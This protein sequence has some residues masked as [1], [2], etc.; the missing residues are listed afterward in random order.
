MSGK[1]NEVNVCCAFSCLLHTA[2]TD[3]KGLLTERETDIIS[4][5]CTTNHNQ[6]CVS[7][8]FHKDMI[9]NVTVQNGHL[10]D[11]SS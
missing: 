11:L 10:A 2:L 9:R 5:G 7:T 4:D 1:V 3:M 8:M 6:Q